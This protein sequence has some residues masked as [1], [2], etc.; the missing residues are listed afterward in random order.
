M[1][2]EYLREGHRWLRI[3]DPQW[4]DPLDPT[5]ARERGGR[6]NPPASYSTLYFNEDVETARA[7]FRV[8]VEQWPYEP[9]DLRNDTGPM[10]VAA[11]LPRHQQVADLHSPAGLDEA[12]LPTTYP[13]DVNGDPIPHKVCQS[14]GHRARQAGLKGIL[15]RSANS[16]RGAGRELAWFPA[17][18]RSQARLQEVIEY[19]NWF[20]VAEGN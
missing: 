11:T 4:A 20:W 7:N 3:A 1:R 8:F 10:L 15:C 13:A 5:Y 16:S 19:A 6:W 18:S 2:T 14:I 9:E 12:G 17:T